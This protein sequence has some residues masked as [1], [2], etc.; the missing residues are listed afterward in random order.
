MKKKEIFRA[1]TIFQ[2][3][4]LEQGQSDKSSIFH[5][6]NRYFTLSIF[7]PSVFI[8]FISDLQ[9]KV[10]LYQIESKN[11]FLSLY[12]ELAADSAIDIMRR[13]LH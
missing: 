12:R 6:D 7:C 5:A 3:A 4:T 1:G 9:S 13:Y 11:V 10:P 8:S 2:A